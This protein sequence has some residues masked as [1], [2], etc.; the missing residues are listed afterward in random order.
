MTKQIPTRHWHTVP[1]L[2]ALLAILGH[3]AGAGDLN[4]PAAPDDPTSAMFTL[5]DLW[6]RLDHGATTVP[7]IG[8]F[9]QPA[10]GP[11]GTMMTLNQIMAIMPA[12]NPEGA[13]AGE[14]LEGKT[15]WSLLSSAWGLQT[16]SM[17]NIGRQDI[18]PS[19]VEQA[20]Q[21]GYHN[22]SGRVAGD[23]D[24]VASNIASG[25]AIFGVPGAAV[26][27]SGT[28]LDTDVL[29][30]KTFS[31]DSGAN[32]SG[33]MV[34][35]G[36]QSITPGTSPQGIT[37]GYHNGTGSVAGDANLVSGYI[38]KGTAIFGVTGTYESP[39]CNC[40]IGTVWNAAN[41]GQRWCDNGDGTVTDLLGAPVPTGGKT[42][43]RCLVWLKDA[44][45]GGGWPWV[46]ATNYADA[47][48][49]AGTLAPGTAG[50]ND[51]SD[52]WDWRLPTRSELRALTASA[53][54]ER[55]LSSSPGPFMHV[56]AGDYW[57][58][59]SF[60]LLPN[61]AAWRLSLLSGDFGAGDKTQS[62]YVW[63]VRRGR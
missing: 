37:Q 35:V 3:S 22:G 12:V 36:Q 32:I 62:F 14:V 6:N 53:G 27:A 52:V 33:A 45:W 44:G 13:A 59:T 28:A 51:G 18:T 8:P 54:I 24:L 42:K 9:V 56:Q 30:G 34:N 39:P 48:A 46:D 11:T 61:D 15:Y 4:A 60:G 16:G 19:T 40:N 2:G 47:H 29:T 63:P 55:I 10:T 31:N 5:M 38:K 49:R 23:A 50:L 21:A 26:V 17:P 43:G 41:G 57:S 25:V 1:L 58:S 7:C 20:I